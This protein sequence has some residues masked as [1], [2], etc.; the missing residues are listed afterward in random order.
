MEYSYFLDYG[1]LLFSLLITVGSSIH[2]RRTYAKTKKIETKRD[3]NGYDAAR[4]ILDSNDLKNVGINEVPVELSDHYDPRSKQV[5]ISTDVYRLP[6]IAS[7]AVASHECGHALQ[8]KEGY[9]FLRLR[10]RIVPIVNLASSLGYVVIMIGIFAG[11]LKLLWFGILLELIILAFQL[12]TLP[13]EFNASRRALQQIEKLNLVDSDELKM[14]KKM[15]TAA[16][17]T[18]VA[19]VSTSIL[20]IFR[21][22]LIARRDD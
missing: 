5:T 11:I 16:A 21:L 20:E 10:S 13:V 12:I 18:Y 6:T 9:F 22:V 2:I 1:I 14:C 17:L 4:K 15:L 8:D 19:A 3:I 7:I